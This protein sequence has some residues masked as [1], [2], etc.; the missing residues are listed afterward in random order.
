MM[1]ASPA[2]RS[3]G[4]LPAFP[5]TQRIVVKGGFSSK[6]ITVILRAPRGSRFAAQPHLL[7]RLFGHTISRVCCQTVGTGAVAGGQGAGIVG[8]CP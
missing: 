8:C 6:D 5:P 3:A 4:C 2:E 1:P 7:K